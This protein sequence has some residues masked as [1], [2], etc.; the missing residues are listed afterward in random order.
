MRTS[1]TRKSLNGRVTTSNV[2]RNQLTAV[3]IGSA[4]EVPH[5]N[6]NSCIPIT[7]PRIAPT[8]NALTIRASFRRGRARRCSPGATTTARLTRS[9]TNAT[10]T[11]AIPTTSPRPGLSMRTVCMISCPKPAAPTSVAITTIPKA[12][13]T[14]WLMP[15]MMEGTANG[16]CTFVSVCRF[17]APNIFAASTADAGTC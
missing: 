8:N 6:G 10:A 9:R 2:S 14:V 4:N 13:I 1:R 3:S 11:T 5:E 7:R 15:A 17:V 16:N 12:I